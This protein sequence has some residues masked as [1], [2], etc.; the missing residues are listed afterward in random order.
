VSDELA[1][2][3]Q[4]VGELSMEVELLR[5]RIERSCIARGC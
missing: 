3:M 5:S 1:T 4:R 2:A